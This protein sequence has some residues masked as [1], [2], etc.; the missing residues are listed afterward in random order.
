MFPTLPAVAVPLS[1]PCPGQVTNMA[2]VL[3]SL[4]LKP[5]FSHMES[6]GV[7]A[8]PEHSEANEPFNSP[9]MACLSHIS[10]RFYSRAPV[11]AEPPA[12]GSAGNGGGTAQPSLPHKPLP[13]P[14]WSHQDPKHRAGSAPQTA[15]PE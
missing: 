11:I 9:I 15:P 12:L 6:T 7:F 2:R 1:V 13:Y 14:Y 3:V 10:F 4:L 8:P 5:E